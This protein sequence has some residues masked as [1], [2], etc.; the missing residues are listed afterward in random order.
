[1]ENVFS[2][3]IS[4]I[5]LLLALLA[6]IF[7]FVRTGSSDNRSATGP[8]GPIITPTRNIPRNREV[9]GPPG[10]SSIQYQF[11]NPPITEDQC[12]LTPCIVSNLH[13]QY[14]IIDGPGPSEGVNLDFDPN[15]IPGSQFI[16][17]SDS[18]FT[19]YAIQTTCGSG[20]GGCFPDCQNPV[21]VDIT[22]QPLCFNNINGQA[23]LF[24]GTLIDQNT[25][26]VGVQDIV[27]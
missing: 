8:V 25:V 4:I 17:Q 24:T 19:D 5:A 3:V 1:M 13:N 14:I 26:I 27:G 9:I 7:V 16:I 18:S 12:V 15:L 20:S 23:A 6:F 22:G 11:N 2:I 21:Y 10:S